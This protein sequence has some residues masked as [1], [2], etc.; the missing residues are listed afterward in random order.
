MKQIIIVLIMVTGLAFCIEDVYK[1]HANGSPKVVKVYHTTYGKLNLVKEKGYYSDGSQKYLKT[2]SKG[3]LQNHH[4]WGI[5]GK[6]VNKNKKSAEEAVSKAVEDI[7]ESAIEARDDAG[8]ES[9]ERKKDS[10]YSWHYDQ[11]QEVIDECKALVPE[12]LG[13]SKASDFC[14]CYIGE[15]AGKMKYKDFRF[16]MDHPKLSEKDELTFMNAYE[17]CMHLA[18]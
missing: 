6:R 12:A 17:E 18:E 15:I 16:A 2:Y 7:V 5:D 11:K 9:K 8:A 1:R 3:N 10:S 14:R 4:E 13:R